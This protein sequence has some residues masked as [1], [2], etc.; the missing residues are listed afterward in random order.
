MECHH[1]GCTPGLVLFLVGP[2]LEVA[3]HFV[4][5][6][7]HGLW[8]VLLDHVSLTKGK[9]IF[10]GLQPPNKRCPSMQVL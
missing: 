10:L 9:A 2:F 7:Y 5:S 8:V 3:Q 6:R 1:T 4:T